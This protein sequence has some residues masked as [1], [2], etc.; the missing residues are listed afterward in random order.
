[1]AQI[2]IE[3]KKNEFI[4][5]EEFARKLGNKFIIYFKLSVNLIKKILINKIRSIDFFIE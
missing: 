3:K 5:K 1:M 2:I 4:L